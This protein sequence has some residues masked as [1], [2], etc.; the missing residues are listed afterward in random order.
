[1]ASSAD[2]IFDLFLSMIS[3]YRLTTL[4]Q[5]SGSS[6][7]NL[8][9]EPWLL[10]SI[11]DFEIV[12]DQDLTYSTTTQEFTETLTQKN[13][14]ILAQ[15]MVRYWLS[16]EVQD[17]TQMRLHVQDKDFRTFAEANN[18]REKQSL[19]NT[20]REEISQLLVDYKLQDADLWTQWN[21]QNF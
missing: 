12:C 14:N 15:I 5:T 6:V 3:D 4:F 7:L 20:K 8:Y 11:T 1:M 10:F 17:I 16:K 18:L 2:S 9:L 21:L 19:L 13:K